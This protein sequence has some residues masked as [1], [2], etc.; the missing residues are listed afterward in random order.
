MKLQ[1][2]KYTSAS[3]GCDL[4]GHPVMNRLDCL[5]NC[6]FYSN[7]FQVFCSLL[8]LMRHGI[9]PDQI[10]YAMGYK[11]FKRDPDLDIY[12]DFHKIN[13]NQSLD[14]FKDVEIPDSN[15]YQPNLYDFET[16][17]KIVNRF[18][19]PSDVVSER[20]KFLE[21]KYQI[22]T[23]KTISVSYRGT[24][25]GTELTLASPEEYLSVVKDILSQ[26]PDFKVLLQTDQTQVIQYFHSHFDDKLVFFEETPSTT[27]NLVIWKIIEDNGG[28][29]VDWQQWCDAAFRIVSKCRYVVNH[30]GNVAMFT[31]LYRGNLENVYQF[32]EHGVLS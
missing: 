4:L 12:P 24:D 15:K 2:C 23:T 22:D 16:Y 21:E 25:K 26:N 32:N 3:G 11:H 14:L 7:Q 27:S 30:T 28:D 19:N 29:S 9:V 20:I 8:I 13:V 10:S 17:N 6:G 18:F 1:N 5:W 31:N